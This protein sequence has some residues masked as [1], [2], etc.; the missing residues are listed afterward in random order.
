MAGIIYPNVERQRADYGTTKARMAKA[1]G[2]SESA[3][4]NKL[5]GTSEFTAREI[6]TLAKWWNVTSDSLLDGAVVVKPTS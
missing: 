6:M 3:L 4:A 5:D 1:L 2:I